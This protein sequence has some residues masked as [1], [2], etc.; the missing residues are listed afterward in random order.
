VS[1][2]PILGFIANYLVITPV[3]TA[4]FYLVSNYVRRNQPVE[5]GSFFDGFQFTVPLMLQSAAMYGIILVILSPTI[6]LLY[7]TG[8]VEWYIGLI[9]NPLE[10]PAS[11]PVFEPRIALIFLLNM[12]P[13]LYIGI[14][15]LWAPHFILFHKMNFWEAME[16]SRRLITRKWFSV[17]TLPLSLLGIFFLV[18]VLLGFLSFVLPFVGMAITFLV[19]IGILFVAPAYFCM[20]YAAFEDVMGLGEEEEADQD[21]LHHLIE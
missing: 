1:I 14:A 3:L 13:L 4:G 10:S 7:N 2:I 12:L 15:Y 5:F 18:F 8:I 19:S 11:P 21:L 17:F 9:R 16:A 6:Y 20:I